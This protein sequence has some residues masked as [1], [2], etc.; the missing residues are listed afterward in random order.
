MPLVNE[1]MYG[2]A[3]GQQEWLEVFNNG[4]SALDL[5]GWVLS[6]SR[7]STGISPGAPAPLGPGEYAILCPDDSVFQA[8]WPDVDC[9]LIEPEDWLV[10]NDAT[11]QGEQ[12]ADR[13]TLFDPSM[14]AKDY[15]PYDDS[16][17]GGSGLSLERRSADSPGY[18]QGN[19]G[20]CIDESGATPGRENSLHA[21]GQGGGEGTFALEAWPDPFSPDGD[22]VDDL[23]MLELSMPADQ[24]S[25]S[26]DI[27]NVQGRMLISLAEDLVCGPTCVICWDG[28]GRNGE[29]LPVGRYLVHAVC[30]EL[31]SGDLSDCLCVV[32]L[33]RRLSG[34]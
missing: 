14:Q 29:R 8:T 15:V 22:G 30:R 5:S 18:V 27:Y 32:V 34:T 7:D 16:W 20:S 28:S 3:Q 9:L 2:P 13:I 23:L 6:D 4:G 11:Q 26:L 1:L 17:G 21:S 31:P 24:N 19:W 33:A 12:W 25:L 10:L